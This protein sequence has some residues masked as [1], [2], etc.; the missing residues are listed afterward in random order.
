MREIRPSTTR[1]R[2][3]S[4]VRRE[5][6]EG[7]RQRILDAGSELAHRA[8]KWDW[9]E[10]TIA[11]IA[12]QAGVSERTVYRHFPSEKQLHEALMRR[13]EQEA[14]V[15]Y[16]TLALGNVGEMTAKLFASLPSF[17][18]APTLP[19]K[20]RTFPSSDQRR[21]ESLTRAVTAATRGWTLEERKLA[22]A[23][24]DVLWT[25]LSFERLVNSWGFATRDATR[26]V[27]WAIELIEQAIRAGERPTAAR[28]PRSKR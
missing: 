16:E 27:T 22:A 1:R 25:P 17:A 4:P 13:L 18:A 9:R 24:L 5:Q 28:K 12:Q 14:G 23:V 15:S 3:E 8:S 6:R 7:T 2:Y 11:A 10:L 26:A 20:E 19:P 21:R